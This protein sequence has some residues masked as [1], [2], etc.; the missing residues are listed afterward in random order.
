MQRATQP[1]SFLT[2]S[3]TLNLLLCQASSPL[4]GSLNFLIILPTP[5]SDTWKHSDNFAYPSPAL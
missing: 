3:Q 2:S 5:L 1:Q 4:C